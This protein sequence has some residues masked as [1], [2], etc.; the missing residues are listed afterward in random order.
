MQDSDENAAARKSTR[1]WYH[2]L[3]ALGVGAA[4]TIAVFTTYLSRI[5]ENILG[6]LSHSGLWDSE[7]GPELSIRDARISKI[8]ADSSQFWVEVVVDNKS[9]TV[10]K[11]CNLS[12]MLEKTM[13]LRSAPVEF[14]KRRYQEVVS[15]PFE[16]TKPI[17][18]GKAKT[19]LECEQSVTP[20]EDLS[21]AELED[22]VPA[23]MKLPEPSPALTLQE[24]PPPVTDSRTAIT[25][26]PVPEPLPLPARPG[27]S[28]FGVLEEQ[29]FDLC[30]FHDFTARLVTKEA[31]VTILS[32]DRAIPDRNF[33]GYERSIPLQTPTKLWDH[34]V[35]SVERKSLAGTIQIVFS[36]T[37]DG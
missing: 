15:F 36:S 11:K 8:D 16:W 29:K 30:G 5:E 3:A 1:A 20:S 22:K 26:P 34:C 21:T 4:A 32:G 12:I 7:I 13:L 9:G 17:H 25:A 10:I 14:D 23:S 28:V 24:P 37:V 6:L 18:S 33:R 2:R 35:V 31:R 19:R 27:K